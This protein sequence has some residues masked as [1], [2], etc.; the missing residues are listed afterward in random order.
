MSEAAFGNVLAFPEAPRR[1]KLLRRVKHGANIQVEGRG[2][3]FDDFVKVAAGQK[4]QKLSCVHHR[5]HF[6]IDGKEALVMWFCDGTLYQKRMSV[7]AAKGLLELL[8]KA[9]FGLDQLN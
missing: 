1:A 7:T 2:P 9:G 6:I 3:T 4:V 5:F 8:E